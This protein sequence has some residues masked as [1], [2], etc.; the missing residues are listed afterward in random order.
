MA[1]LSLVDRF[2]ALEVERTTN[3]WPSEKEFCV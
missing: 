1:L 2:E 3:L